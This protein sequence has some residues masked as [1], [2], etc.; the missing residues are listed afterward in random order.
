MMVFHGISNAIDEVVSFKNQHKRKH[1]HLDHKIEAMKANNKPLRMVM[2]YGIGLMSILWKL[3][4]IGSALSM[5]GF[6]VL[7]DGP[8]RWPWDS[9]WSA[10]QS[11][12]RYGSRRW[13]TPWANNKSARLAAEFSFKKQL[14][15]WH[16]TTMFY[17]YVYL[18][19]YRHLIINISAVICLW[20][21]F[22]NKLP[23]CSTGPSVK[24]VIHVNRQPRG[25]G[26]TIGRHGKLLIGFFIIHLANWR[27]PQHGRVISR[28]GGIKWHKY[29][30]A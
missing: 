20:I 4:E 22:D 6:I 21:T 29:I 8:P 23:R 3:D 7:R 19:N 9:P 13:N 10:W 26:S 30:C 16:D 28:N 25:N 15:N 17:V 27:V 18:V 24:R 5:G 14:I 11:G 1:P 2:V 12:A